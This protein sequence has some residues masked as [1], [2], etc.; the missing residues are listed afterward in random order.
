MNRQDESPTPL[1]WQ[2]SNRTKF[3]AS[4]LQRFKKTRL[5]FV[6][7]WER[8]ERT[9]KKSLLPVTKKDRKKKKR[10]FDTDRP[11]WRPCS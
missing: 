1:H 10:K 9:V 5:Y 7:E 4:V 6:K 8:K 3:K 11:T 2:L